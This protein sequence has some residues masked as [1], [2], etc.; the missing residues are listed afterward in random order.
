MP[1]ARLGVLRV[2]AAGGGDQGL[3]DVAVGAIAHAFLLSCLGVSG[4]DNDIPTV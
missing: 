2:S 1:R 4:L 3:T